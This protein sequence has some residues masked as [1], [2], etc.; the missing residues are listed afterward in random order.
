MYMVEIGAGTSSKLS[1]VLAVKIEALNKFV[2]LLYSGSEKVMKAA[3]PQ[4]K[5][6]ICRRL[7]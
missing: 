6:F 3:I 4:T 2:I 1:G 7:I 5:I